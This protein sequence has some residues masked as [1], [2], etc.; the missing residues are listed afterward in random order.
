MIQAHVHAAQGLLWLVGTRGIR[1]KAHYV[2]VKLFPPASVMRSRV[3]WA[4]SGRLALD[5]DR[6]SRS[7]GKREAE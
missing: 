4:R 3:P 5:S 1:A 6:Q 2:R 7:T